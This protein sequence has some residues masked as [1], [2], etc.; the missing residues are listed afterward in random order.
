MS[1]SNHCLCEI[2]RTVLV[3]GPS[4]NVSVRQLMHLGTRPVLC[5]LVDLMNETG[6]LLAPIFLSPHM[7]DPCRLHHIQLAVRHVLAA[8]QGRASPCENCPESVV[9]TPNTE[10]TAAQWNIGYTRCPE[11]GS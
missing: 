4:A 6:P 7:N 10:P 9:V 11:C 3:P 1:S 8:E 5:L 2:C